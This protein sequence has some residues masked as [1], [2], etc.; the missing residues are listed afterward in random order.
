MPARL[1]LLLS[2]GAA[3]LAACD[4][5]G[6]DAFQEEVVVSAV[7]TADGPL[8]TVFLSRTVPIA[9]PLD[10]LA[11]VIEG[12]AVT[13][14]L[15]APD[16]SVEAAYAYGDATGGRYLPDDPFAAVLPGRRYRL[17]AVAPGF[18]RPVTAETTVPEAFAVVRPP[19]DSVVY[20]RGAAPTFDVTPSLFDGR[21]A[22][23]VL[24]I[25]ALEPDPAALTPFAAQLF[26]ERDVTLV[27][28]TTTTSPL[29][30]EGTF[31]HNPDG[32]VRIEVPWF[33][34]NFYGPT[35]VTV[36]TP[37]D[38]LVAFLEFQAVQTIPTTISPGEIPDVP[39]N[40]ENGVGV[41]G[42]VAQATVEV[43]VGQP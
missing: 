36:S 12:A 8:P 9:E 14:S 37:D 27:S 33:S 15:L 43:F 40:V 11:Y 26:N 13:V 20:Q 23:Y 30:N 28:L 34:F 16:G 3:L 4:S 10:S 1:T 7:L 39:T 25:E 24:T 18:D 35:R 42:A 31:L 32:S 29:L 17:D 19:P 41:F 5:A 22:V 38:A 6:L 2:L 21:Q